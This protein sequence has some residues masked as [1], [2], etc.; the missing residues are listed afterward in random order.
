MEN[1]IKVKPLGRLAK[2]ADIL[3]V[4]LMYLI[5]GTFK[6]VPQRGHMW[7][8]MGLS[9]EA[10]EKLDKSIMVHCIGVRNEM[11][12]R[13]F[14]LYHLPIFGGWRGYVA[15]ERVNPGKDWY[16]GYVTGDFIG[17]SRIKLS[18]RV[19]MLIGHSNVS[20]FGID[21]DTHE[22]ISIMEIGRGRIGDGGE[23]AK[24]KLL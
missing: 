19:R 8:N 18:G 5:S 21:A 14:F 22:Q 16:V 24:E 6:E 2:F 1:R 9:K 12:A 10:V 13:W 20:F 7:N 15:L 17:A 23:F 4:P 11:H 3:M